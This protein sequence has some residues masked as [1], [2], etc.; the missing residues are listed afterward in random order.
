MRE[1]LKKYIEEKFISERKHPILDLWIYNYTPRCQYEKKWDKI[2]LMCRG[3]ILDKSG[4]IIARPFQKFFNVGEHINENKDIPNCEFKV[5]EKY[6]GSLGILYFHGDQPKIATRG[7][8]ESEQAIKGTEILDKKFKDYKF[9][10]NYTYLFEIIY[11]N[12][13]IVVDYEGKEDLILLAVIDTVSGLD[14]NLDNFNEFKTAK[15]YDGI[16]DIDELSKKQEN[17]K[18]G[19]VIKFKSGLRLKFKFE[20]YVRLH[21]LVTQ[22]N[23][24]RIWEHLKNKESIEELLERVPD[25]FFK[26]VKQIVDNL[27]KN[28][29]RIEE[30]SKKEFNKIKHIKDRKDFAQAALKHMTKSILFSMRDNKNY[31]EIIWRMIKPKTETPFK[32]EI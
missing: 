10:K 27:I 7:S 25:E 19:Y 11:P 2:T 22:T 16:I 26:W 9:N 24:K 1:I 18:E 32:K 30:E 12:N 14:L 13:R 21:R 29:I 3:L 28:Y 4:E 31:E 6:D 8:F 20:E 15:R 17:N 23:S 5:F